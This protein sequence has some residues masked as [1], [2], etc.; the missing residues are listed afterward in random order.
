[1]RSLG[2]DEIIT[3]SF[4]SPKAYDKVNHPKEKQ[5]S[6][7]ITNPLGEDL[8]IMRTTTLPSMMDII[9]RNINFRNFWLILTAL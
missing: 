5:I 8:S 4:I 1:M 2:F 3:Y 7:V 6:T 9:V